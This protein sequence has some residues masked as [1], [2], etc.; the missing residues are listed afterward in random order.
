MVLYQTAKQLWVILLVQKKAKLVMILHKDR[1][2]S[3]MLINRMLQILET[4]GLSGEK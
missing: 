2:L 4:I 3:L 1:L